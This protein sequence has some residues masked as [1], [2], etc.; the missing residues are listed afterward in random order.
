MSW[1]A[2]HKFLDVRRFT[3]PLVGTFE[4]LQFDE[5]HP[6]R[7]RYRRYAQ[8]R[9]KRLPKRGW[10]VDRLP[11]RPYIQAKTNN[12][13]V[14]GVA[15]YFKPIIADLRPL[16]LH[17]LQSIS[18]ET[19]R[20]WLL[21]CHQMRVTADATADGVPVPEGPHRDGP[22]YVLVACV[23]RENV[24]GGETQL[25]DS[26]DAP[27]FLSVTLRPGQAI[28]FDD[29]QVYHDVSKLR[30]THGRKGHR[31][32]FIIGFID[33][34]RGRYGEDWERAVLG[35]P[36]DLSTLEKLAAEAPIT[37]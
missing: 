9:A 10:T 33:W 31:D 8:I 28:L 21:N 2:S 1:D 7:C 35:K 32:I 26:L 22:D 29:R 27:P 5:Y 17:T 19:A 13:L 20:D 14:G 18:H 3:D 12:R 37:P 25:M 16:I 23:A 24:S 15:R 30:S 4:A 11:L 6:N 34:Q 36:V